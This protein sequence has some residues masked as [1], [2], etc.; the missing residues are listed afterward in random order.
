MVKRILITFL[1][2]NFLLIKETFNFLNFM[3]SEETYPGAYYLVLNN[4]GSTLDG[5]TLTENRADVSIEQGSK[6]I[7]YAKESVNSS[8]YE[9][10]NKTEMHSNEECNQENLIT[11][12]KGGTYRVSG[13]LKGQLSIS[14]SSQEKI[15]LVLEGVDIYCGVAPAVIVYKAYEM[16]TKNYE[17]EKIQIDLKKAI[18]LN[19]DEA[20]VK[21]IIADNSDNI[22]SG[23]HV[24]D[25]RDSNNNRIAKYDGAFYSKVSLS[26]KGETKG[27]GILNIIG[28]NE[29]LDSEKHLIISDGNINIASQDDGINANNDGGSVVLI[30]GGNVKINGGLKEGDGIDSNGYLIIQNGKVISAGSKDKCGLTADLGIVINGGTV[31]GVG[32]GQPWN[33]NNS[34]QQ[35]M[36]L[37]FYPEIP[38]NR[39]LY[40]K[41]SSGKIL[42]SF[43]PST[44]RFISGTEPR[45]YKGAIISH[46]SFKLNEVYYLY[47]GNIQFHASPSTDKNKKEA[48]KLKTDKIESLPKELNLKSIVSTFDMYYIEIVKNES[49]SESSSS[50]T[51]F[52][53]MNWFAFLI[54]LF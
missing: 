36:H 17:V 42:L 15:T 29:G 28:D 40:V 41:D 4:E 11:I 3:T 26:I 49:K 52:S 30:K 7:H 33:N 6:I 43:N 14:I 53:F 51:D 23:S 35:I 25:F 21:I 20:G 54:I 2:L 45:G 1:L 10:T 22:I 31:I 50:K 9:D 13:T 37:R 19:P 39:K 44:S 32:S 48:P 46:P 18:E 8:N 16:D 47:L 24:A 27:N 38:K 12:K 5:E 34:T